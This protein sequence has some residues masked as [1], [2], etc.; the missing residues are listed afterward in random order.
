[1]QCFVEVCLQMLV[2]EMQA[3]DIELEAVIVDLKLIS[4]AI[5]ATPYPSLTTCPHP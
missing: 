3:D 1:M 4:F 5:Y 2:L